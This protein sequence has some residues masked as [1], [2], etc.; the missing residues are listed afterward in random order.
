LWCSQ[1][2]DHAKADWC[3]IFLLTKYES[4]EKNK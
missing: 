1:G 4:G 2:G 3:K